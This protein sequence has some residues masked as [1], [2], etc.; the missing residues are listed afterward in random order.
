MEMKSEI[1][2]EKDKIVVKHSDI[3]L[4]YQDKVVGT[5]VQFDSYEPKVVD[6]V[7]QNL[8]KELDSSEARV[9]EID[10]KIEELSKSFL[11]RERNKI[12]EFIQMSN[13][14]ANYKQLSELKVQRTNNSKAVEKI[15]EELDL[16][17]N[18]KK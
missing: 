8:Q 14:A 11:P 18:L 9:K 17:G 2:M 10:A 13:K 4:M 3:E 15:K 6:K 7:I 5:R 12:K 1:Y 16:L